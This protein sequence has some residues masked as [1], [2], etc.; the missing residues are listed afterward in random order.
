MAAL[1]H[2]RR[3]SGTQFDDLTL[4]SQ[5]MAARPEAPERRQSGEFAIERQLWFSAEQC[6]V[7]FGPMR[8]KLT[9]TEFR[10]LAYLAEHEGN[11]ISNEH[12]LTV[13]LARPPKRDK[14]LVRVHL[15]NIRRK[16]GALS[17]C[18]ESQRGQGTIFRM[19]P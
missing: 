18:I 17:W 8:V 7:G 2:V 19:R 10:I 6:E 3:D 1:A 13:V 15:W 9:R 4:A 5:T 12:I 14:A 16:L 11:W